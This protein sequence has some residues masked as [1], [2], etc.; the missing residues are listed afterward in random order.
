MSS[1]SSQLQGPYERWTLRLELWLLRREILQEIRRGA[2][3]SGAATN[4]GWSVRPL[5]KP[6]FLSLRALGVLLLAV[7]FITAL[8]DLGPVM[9]RPFSLFV[10]A[11]LC[12]WS[13]GMLED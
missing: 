2:Q 1:S 9:I 10:G 5:A 13:V 7:W 11:W 6:F 3:E 4:Y 12:W 8:Y